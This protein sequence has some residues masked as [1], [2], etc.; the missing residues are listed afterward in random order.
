VSVVALGVVEL[1]YAYD[2]LLAVAFGLM[3]PGVAVLHSLHRAVRSSGAVLGTIA[4]TATVA[5]GLAGSVALDLR[6]AALVVLGVWW[7]TIGKMWVETGVMPRAFGVATATLAVVAF[8]GAAA[9]VLGAGLLQPGISAG[10]A[11]TVV[12]VAIGLWLLGLAAGLWSA[13]RSTT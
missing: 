8:V 10:Q 5:V 7:W 13:A 6:P 11:W 4:G 1:R 3:L 9:L 12:H 2:A